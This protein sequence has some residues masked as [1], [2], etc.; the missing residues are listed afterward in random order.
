MDSAVSIVHA[1]HAVLEILNDIF[2][3]FDNN[4]FTFCLFIDLKKAFDTVNYEILLSKL[5]SYGFR[6]I[7]NDWFK[8]YLNWS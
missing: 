5:E 2:T 8:L 3:N 4:Q 1:Q 6:G 7:V